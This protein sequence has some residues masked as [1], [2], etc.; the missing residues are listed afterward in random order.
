MAECS[1][2]TPCLRYKKEHGTR[3]TEGVVGPFK[4]MKRLT[5]GE[6]AAGL[7]QGDASHDEDRL[8]RDRNSGDERMMTNSTVGRDDIDSCM[9]L[10]H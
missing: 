1:G 5:S 8:R 4:R 6:A 3:L 2:E 10:V 9:A 7:S